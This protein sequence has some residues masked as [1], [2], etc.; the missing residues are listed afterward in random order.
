M[1]AQDV[2]RRIAQCRLALP[3]RRVEPVLMAGYS[4][5]PLIEKLGIKSGVTLVILNAPPGYLTTLAP[6]PEGVRVVTQLRGP[7]D[8]IHVFATR[9]EELAARMPSLK[10]ALDPSGMLWISWPKGASK[11]PTDLNENVMREIGLRHGLVDVKVCA[12]DD[13][14]SGLKVVYRLRDRT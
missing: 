9:R 12:I 8:V 2:A 4:P 6:L 14:W 7:L 13:T 10:Q 11:Q 3:R 1:A 5:R